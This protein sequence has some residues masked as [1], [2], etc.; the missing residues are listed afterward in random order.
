MYPHLLHVDDAGRLLASGSGNL[1]GYHAVLLNIS[2]FFRLWHFV[3]F[4]IYRSV[5]PVASD[6]KLDFASF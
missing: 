6:F 1:V 4:D 2:G 5:T 3:L